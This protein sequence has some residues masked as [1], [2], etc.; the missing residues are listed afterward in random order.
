MEI[1]IPPGAL[2]VRDIPEGTKLKVPVTWPGLPILI[3]SPGYEPRITGNQI[4]VAVPLKEVGFPASFQYDGVTAALRAN[5]SV[6]SPLLCVVDVFDI[7]SGT[8]SLPGTV[9]TGTP[10][11]AGPAS[12]RAST[13]KPT[14]R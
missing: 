11:A 3:D 14:T 1:P 6:H 10:A 4:R 5:A 2:K 8:L 7:A 12:T 13:R 9:T